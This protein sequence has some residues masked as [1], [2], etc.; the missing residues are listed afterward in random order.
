MSIIHAQDIIWDT[1]I[2]EKKEIAN[3]LI[4]K[5]SII[6]GLLVAH[7]AVDLDGH[8]QALI[9]PCLDSQTLSIV[10]SLH[11]LRT[12]EQVVV[13]VGVVASDIE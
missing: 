3:S 2:K 9:P 5:K 11:W 8:P 4:Q 7:D 12:V 13:S 10:S 1:N 6:N